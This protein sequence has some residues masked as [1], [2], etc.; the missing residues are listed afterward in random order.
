MR[1]ASSRGVGLLDLL[2]PAERE[3]WDAFETTREYPFSAFA[4]LLEK[5]A[6]ATG[7]DAFAIGYVSCL[8]AR[9]SGVFQTI[10]A[11]STS[12]RDA[13]CGICRLC[14]VKTSALLLTYEEQDENGFIDFVFEPALRD[15]PQ[16]IAGEI[17][18]V[19]LRVREQSGMQLEPSFVEFAF[20]PPQAIASFTHLFGQNV[21]FSANYNRIGYSLALLHEPLANYSS[22][23]PGKP[24]DVH[25]PSGDRT[26]IPQRVA[27][28]LRGAMQRGEASEIHACSVLQIGRRTL[29]RELLSAGTS[30]RKLLEDERRRTAEYYLTT[31]DLS[32]LAISGLLGYSEQSAFS[33]ACRGW[34]GK[35]PTAIRRAA[36]R[37]SSGVDGTS[38]LNSP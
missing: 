33:R 11:N 24:P 35:T 38:A 18:I 3:E 2:N 15:K 4:G 10:I 1:Y 14:A 16:L 12:L 23:A 31:T 37:G 26:A 28:F 30:F 8:P 9:S 36:L 22:R 29:Q 32:L 34:F 5:C 13:F 17:A 7:D 21:R 25:P 27:A 19:A 20:P 6:I